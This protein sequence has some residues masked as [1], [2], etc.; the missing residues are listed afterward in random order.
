MKRTRSPYVS[1]IRKRRRY[2]R[3]QR[4]RATTQKL[5][6]ARTIANMRTAGF[7]GIENKF[8]DTFLVNSNLGNVVGA[9]PSA[10]EHD[11]AT[12]LCI[13]APAQGNTQSDRDGRKMTITSILVKGHIEKV[14]TATLQESQSYLVAIV[15][16][17]QTNG[18]QLAS[19]NVYTNPSAVNDNLGLLR[20]L[21]YSSRFTILGSKI[22]HDRPMTS[23]GNGTAADTGASLVPFS[24]FKKCNIPVNFNATTEGVASVVDNSIHIV[25]YCMVT[26]STPQL[27]YNARVRF[28]G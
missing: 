22:I 23:S 21:K 26:G 24:F 18:A 2:N 13:S 28:I 7:L 5:R 11:P 4:S 14:A 27:T 10:G 6:A 16:D 25:A 8:Y 19:E 9:N 1:G 12:H 15:Q 3:N 17:R 20:N